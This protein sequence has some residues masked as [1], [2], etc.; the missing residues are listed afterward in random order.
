MRHGDDLLTTGA[1]AALLG[2]S[3]QHVTDLCRAGVLPFRTIGTH[4]RIALEDLERFA[5]RPGR[6][7]P[8]AIARQRLRS[9]WLHRAVAGRLA[10]DP[11][12]VIAL[13]RENLQRARLL[14]PRSRP[15]IDAWTRLIDDPERAMERLTAIDAQ[16]DELRQNS[17]FAGVLDEQERSR[18]LAAFA[19]WWRARHA[20]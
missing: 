16:S 17:P 4:R 12:G 7:A 9:L 11:D 20:P 6:G 10:A 14:H 19:D 18:I 2:C 3:R 8:E 13:A 1:A 5:R 15:W